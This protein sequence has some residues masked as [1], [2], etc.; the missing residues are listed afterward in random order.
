MTH[1]ETI[2]RNTIEHA[3]F[4]QD[5]K[6]DSVEQLRVRLSN[7]KSTDP[8]YDDIM[9]ELIDKLSTDLEIITVYEDVLDHLYGLRV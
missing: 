5:R 9:S 1:D 4:W 3:K 7:L 6:K 2:I 8:Y